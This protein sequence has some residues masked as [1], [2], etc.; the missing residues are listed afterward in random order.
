M[1]RCD[2]VLGDVFGGVLGE[3]LYVVGLLDVRAVCIGPG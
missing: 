2:G 3:A 1:K